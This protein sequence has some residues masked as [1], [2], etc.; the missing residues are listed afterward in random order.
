MRFSIKLKL[1]LT[2]AVVIVLS[3]TTA[4]L[5][6]GNMGALDATMVH[7]LDGPVKRLEMSMQRDIEMLRMVRSEKNLT[8]QANKDDL[9]RF[10][11]EVTKPRQALVAALE[12]AEATASAQGKP[13]WTGARTAV[14]QVGVVHDKIRAAI[15]RGAADEARN[16]SSTQVAQFVNEAAK[17]L[18]GVVE[19]NQAIL[20][21]A[22]TDAGQEYDSALDGHWFDVDRGFSRAM[23]RDQHQPRAGARRGTRESGRDRRSEPGGQGQEQRRDQGP[24]RFPQ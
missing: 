1:G 14:Q 15:E 3:S 23:D 24:G 2:F 18:V 8:M 10:D 9:A 4:W 7:V 21:K 12:A 6:I 16:L 11:A 13:L 20:E 17:N 22:K 19:L 5:G